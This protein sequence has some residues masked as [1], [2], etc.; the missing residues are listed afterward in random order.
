MEHLIKR[1]QHFFITFLCFVFVT[2]L[3]AQNYKAIQGSSF[4]GTLGVGNNPASIV[5]MPFPWDV[6]VVS[7]QFAN[8]T[9]AIT[10]KNFSLLSSDKKTSLSVNAGD[11]KRSEDFNFN[12][13]LLNTRIALGRKRAVAFGANLRGYGNVRTD[14]YNYN[15]SLQNIR[16]FFNNNSNIDSYNAHLISSSW[17]EIFATYSQTVW[18][19]ASARL[20]AGITVKV[21]RGVSG[22]FVQLQNGSAAFHNDPVSPYYTLTGG[23]AKYGYSYNY[24]G[25]SGDKTNSQNVHD[26]IRNT[27]GN[28]SF[29][30]G[31]EYLI[32]Q[33]ST[34]IYGED[35]DYFA[36]DWKIGLSLLDL[37]RNQ[38]KYGDQSS[39]ASHPNA[40]ISDSTLDNKFDFINSVADF[41]DSLSTVVNNFTP[42]TGKFRIRNPARLVINVDRL[43][44]SNF[45][46]NADLSVNFAKLLAGNNLY[47]HEINLLTVTPRWET[48]HWGVYL[49]VQ[50]NTDNKFWVGLAAKAGPLLIGLHNLAY[51]FSKKSIQNGGGYLA[52]VIHPSKITAKK[53][54]GILECPKL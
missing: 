15:D 30:L 31:V 23:D 36:Y 42:V 33:E 41:N 22:A 47:V 24:D 34:G 45:Y 19:N 28:F 53:V 52:L 50:Y 9:N 8:A 4:A 51:L 44:Q 18:E 20:N 16:Q 54:K 49:P 32:T 26:F 3:C 29:D 48:K 7:L 6:D 35:D 43:L 1:S 17:L 38:Y 2:N 11:Y 14:P 40:N 46:I 39:S 13:N 12:I 21:T 27:R 37:G 25:I 5:N 10:I